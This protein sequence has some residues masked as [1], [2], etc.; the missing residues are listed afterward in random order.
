[1]LHY[2][3]N[4]HFLPL[5]LTFKSMIDFH[6]ANGSQNNK[7]GKDCMS[8][9]QRTVMLL[10]VILIKV[11]LINIWRHNSMRIIQNNEHNVL[12]LNHYKFDKENQLFIFFL[13]KDDIL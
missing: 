2:T 5:I 3:L 1:M 12:K 11:F 13:K 4:S 6:V 8:S 10:V 9:N 7:L